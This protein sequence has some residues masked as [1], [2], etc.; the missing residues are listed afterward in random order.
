MS[1]AIFVALAGGLLLGAGPKDNDQADVKKIQGK[2]TI[3]SGV[4]DGNPI[5][6]LKGEVVYTGDKYHWKT[7]DQSGKGTFRLDS[8]K[9]PKHLDA[10]PSDGPIQGQTV[11]HI[12]ELNG[13]SLKLCLAMPGTPRPTEFKSEGGSGW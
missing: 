11:E 3:A 7:G 8:A 6:N 13:D 9:H 4:I 2:W 1:S 12:Y 5:P 10:V